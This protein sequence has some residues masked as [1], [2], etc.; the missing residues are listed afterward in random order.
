MFDFLF[1]EGT[2]PIEGSQNY[3]HQSAEPLTEIYDPENDGIYL[4]DSLGVHEHWDTNVNIFSSERYSGTIENGIDYITCG[5]EYAGPGII[6][7]KPVMKRLYFMGKELCR[8]PATI[9][10]GNINVES[11]ING[12]SEEVEK[13][14][15]YLDG[16]LQHIAED[17]PFT[18]S[19]NKPAFFKHNI[20]AKAY[21]NETNSLEYNLIVWKLF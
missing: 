4:S 2:N 14:E 19:W 15:F 17:E 7:T 5:E 1:A 8:F 21:Y 16:N 3:L 12:L 6:I 20:S 11:R 9:V 10:I 13:V 18:W